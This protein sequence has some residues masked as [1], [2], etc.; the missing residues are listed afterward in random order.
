MFQA[1]VVENMENT[2][3]IFS[4]FFFSEIHAVCEIMWKNIV[5][6][7]RPHMT[8][9]SMRI[10][11]WITKATD[12]HSEFVLLFL[13]NNMVTP[14]LLSVTFIRILRVFFFDPAT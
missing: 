11:C 4:N 7:D 13:H 12:A 6:P 14:T 3:F 5:E 1:N 2:H 9:W 10:A 8:I